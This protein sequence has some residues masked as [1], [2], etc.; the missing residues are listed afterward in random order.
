[1]LSTSDDCN[2]PWVCLSERL[3]RISLMPYD[4]GGSEDCFLKSVSHQL[5]GTPELHF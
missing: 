5:Y 1:M 2:L 3:S 4:V